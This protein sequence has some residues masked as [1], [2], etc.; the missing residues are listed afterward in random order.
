MISLLLNDSLILKALY[1]NNTNQVE[2][3]FYHPSWAIIAG[4]AFAIVFYLFF[5][6]LE[7]KLTI[8]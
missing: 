6:G 5:I 8:Q 7:F 3:F 4:T 2:T 1:Y